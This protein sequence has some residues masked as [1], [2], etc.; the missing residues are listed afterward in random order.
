MKNDSAKTSHYHSWIPKTNWISYVSKT[1][2]IPWKNW[3]HVPAQHCE[4]MR[5]KH[6]S[7]QRLRKL[8]GFLCACRL[9]TKMHPTSWESKGTPPQWAIPHQEVRPYEGAFLKPS[10]PEYSLKFRPA[11]SLGER[12]LW[13]LKGSMAAAPHPFPICFFSGFF[14]RN[15]TSQAARFLMIFVDGLQKL[16][17]PHNP[18]EPTFWSFPKVW[19]SDVPGVLPPLFSGDTAC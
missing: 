8:R 11:I 13:F 15:F 3:S 18:S 4:H 2:Q 16:I 1:L 19:I 14:F 17:T 9:M 5:I 6:Q 10:S 7:S 12:F